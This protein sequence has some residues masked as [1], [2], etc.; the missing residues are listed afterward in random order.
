[1]ETFPCM[2]E[3]DGML[4]KPAVNCSKRCEKCA[5]NPKEQ[6]RRKNQGHVEQEAKSHNLHND[7]GDVVHTVT[8][9]CNVLHF[10]SIR[11]AVAK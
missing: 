9:I 2:F 6:E 11:S 3:Q 5:W 10:P 8:E 1:M 7:D 4:R